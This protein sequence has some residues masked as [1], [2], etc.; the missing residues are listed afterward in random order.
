MTRKLL[1]GPLLALFLHALPAPAQ[2]AGRL[3]A[4]MEAVGRADWARATAEARRAGPVADDIVTWHRLRAGD[5]RAVD[6]AEFLA[7]RPDWPG[8]PL[9]QKVGEKAVAAEAA[10][11]AVIAYFADR[12]PQTATGSLALHA[13]LMQRGDR[14]A[15]DREAVRAWRNL[16]MDASEQAAYLARAGAVLVDHHGGRMVKA[17]AEGWHDNAE[18]MLPLV[19]EGTRAVAAAR[20]ALQQDRPGV[21]ALIAA[22]PDRMAG[23]AGLAKDRFRW[24]IRKDRYDEAADLL[25]ERSGSAESLGVPDDWAGWRA[26]LARREMRVGDAR[27]AYRI[28]ASHHLT[29]GSAYADLE[30]LSGYIA[31][32]KLDDPARALTHFRNLRVAVSGPISLSRAAYWEGRAQEAMGRPVEARAAYAFAAEFQTAFYGLLAAERAGLPF[33]ARLA[34]GEA[35]P[36]W[37][38]LPAAR[39]SVFEAAVML[40]AAGQTDL[41]E[42]FLLHLAEGLDGQAIGALAGLAL[43]WQEWHMALMLAKAAADKGVIWPTAYFPVTGLVG[44]DLPVAPELA[45]SIARRES[46]FDPKVVSPAGARGLMQVMPG[47]AKMMAAKVGLPYEA[48]RLTTDPVYNAKLGSAYLA[49]LVA[50]F[51][52]VPALVAAGYNAGPGR[53]RRWVEELGDPRRG[54]VDVVDWIEHIPFTETRNYV[55]RV[56]ESLPV[57]RARLGRPDAV[58]RLAQEMA[59]R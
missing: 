41:A 12:P 3:A 31:L 1:L 37:R 15:A 21:D 33:D 16:P 10:P 35:Y 39:S 29:Q 17:L 45:L 59:G 42:R 48:A 14:A 5:G 11:A 43:D 19:A 53:P 18:R 36:D 4:A 52:A 54:D 58:P 44:L 22:V 9:L 28:A 38:A 6:Y 57:Y 2:D 24:R 34:G 55:M 25:L 13:A 56:G 50:E 46:E 8:L 30:F 40:R 27:R 49:E 26:T 51:G 32:R 7:R 20:L 23:S 47:T